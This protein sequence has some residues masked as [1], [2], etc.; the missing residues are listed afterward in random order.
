MRN[1]GT[2]APDLG[3]QSTKDVIRGALTL[4]KPIAA[5]PTAP[6][7]ALPLAGLRIIDVGTGNGALVR[8]LLREGADAFGIEPNARLLQAAV[9]E[10]HRPAPRGRWIAASAECLPLR[11]AT[12]DAVLFFNSLHHIRPAG[13]IAALAEAAR[14]LKPGGDLVVIEPLA[15]GS[16][17]E[18]LAPLDDETVVRAAAQAALA[19]SRGRLFGPVSRARFTTTLTF[20]SAEEVVVGFIRADPARAADTQRVMPEIEARFQALGA[21]EPDGRRRFVQPMMM[22]HDRRN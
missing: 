6:T 20:T 10:A 17:F 19:A 4:G 22:Q 8:W 16:Y 2:S 18:L 12:A 15:A 21:G 13:Q 3:E 11:R 14:V 1:S 9:D 7:T 5:V